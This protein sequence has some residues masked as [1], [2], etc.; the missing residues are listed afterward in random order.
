MTIITSDYNTAKVLN[1]FFSNVFNNLNTAE[2]SNCESY[3]N[4]VYKY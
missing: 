1:N 4:Y 2:Y 3:R